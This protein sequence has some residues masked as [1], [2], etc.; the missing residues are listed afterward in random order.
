MGVVCV[1]RHVGLDLHPRG[2][3]HGRDKDGSRPGV[4][5][6]DDPR[7]YR[8]DGSGRLARPGPGRSEDAAAMSEAEG[9]VQAGRLDEACIEAVRR[10]I[11]IPIRNRQRPHTEQV[12]TDAIRHFA[13]G[14]G[15][16]NPL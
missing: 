14:Y 3:D 12:T 1:I 6:A 16:D 7:W 9:S 8:P 10:R 5:A 4:G 15:D 2:W 13:M 11:G